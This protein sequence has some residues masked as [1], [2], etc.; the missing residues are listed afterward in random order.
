MRVLLLIS[1][2]TI[3]RRPVASNWTLQV[4][5]PGLQDLARSKRRHAQVLLDRT[6][7]GEGQE[8][9]SVCRLKAGGKLSPGPASRRAGR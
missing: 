4:L 2:T 7:R 9:I 3:T 8:I 5:V 1:L 6:S